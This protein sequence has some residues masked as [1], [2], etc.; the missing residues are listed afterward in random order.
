MRTNI[1]DEALEVF[2][3][4]LGGVATAGKAGD[5]APGAG[6]PVVRDVA[7]QNPGRQFDVQVARESVQ[8]RFVHVAQ[9]FQLL[10]E[11][12]SLRS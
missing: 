2:F 12:S 4:V 10:V 6:F 7:C 9:F 11:A 1:S 5:A 8:I 3:D